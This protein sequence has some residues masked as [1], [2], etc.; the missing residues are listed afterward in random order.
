MPLTVTTTKEIAEKIVR[1]E[2]RETVYP[3]TDAFVDRVI[4]VKIQL[5][6]YARKN[7][8]DPNFLTR[9]EPDQVEGAFYAG[10]VRV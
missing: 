8:L 3:D 7:L 6:R 1:R 9:S 2:Q 10:T 5:D 4:E